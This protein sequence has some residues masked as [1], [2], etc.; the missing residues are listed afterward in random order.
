MYIGKNKIFKSP[1]FDIGMMINGNDVYDSLFIYNMDK[2]RD[3]MTTVTKLTT[4]KRMDL[5]ASRVSTVSADSTIAIC[6]RIS[7]WEEKQEELL[8]PTTEQ[9]RGFNIANI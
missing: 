4:D 6:N 8:V 7:K 3:E 1:E 9:L 2:N 5:F